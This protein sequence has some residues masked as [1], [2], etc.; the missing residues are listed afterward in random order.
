MA[1]AALAS[2]EHPAGARLQSIHRSSRQGRRVTAAALAA[3][4]VI[5]A[6]LGACA[7]SSE[8][9]DP[10]SQSQVNLGAAPAGAARDRGSVDAWAQAEAALAAA[11]SAW[12]AGDPL[13][14][15]ALANQALRKGVPAEL[16]T[17]FR[18]L[19]VRARSAVV[20]DRIIEI[21]ALPVKDVVAD[22][23]D[24]PLR[25]ALANLS[26]ADIRSP[27]RESGSSDALFVLSVLRE[28]WDIYG[29]VR[30]SEFTL[31]APVTEDL[32]IPPSGEREVQVTIGAE[33][34]K[35]THEGFSVFRIG[36][37]FRP[38]VVRVGESEFFDA[39]PIEPATVR[40]FQKGY[41]QLAADPLSALRKAIAKRSPP[42]VLAAAELL[43]PVERAEA[44]QIL[45]AAAEHDP[46][47]AF[48][49]R[50]SLARLDVLDAPVRAERAPPSAVPGITVTG[51]RP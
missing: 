48:V 23:D 17:K 8:D 39:L 9:L 22:G 32:A 11:E 50:A 25:I 27:R 2:R 4:S 6:A 21:R 45:T 5:A 35:L 3:W 43:A 10:L 19:R 49:L 51:G 31:R 34:V 30:S 7:S 41:E 20:T 18:E 16:E 29:N 26:A 46:P 13:T 14:A 28:D 1:T 47:L 12:Q 42:H 37:I 38:V 44:R 33:Y 24:I 15:V 40:V 36:G